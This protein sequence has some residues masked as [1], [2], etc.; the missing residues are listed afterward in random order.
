MGD[1]DKEEPIP[2]FLVFNVLMLEDYILKVYRVIILRSKPKCM[3]VNV[4]SYKLP[5]IA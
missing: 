1:N 2:L 3:S 5:N 4:P